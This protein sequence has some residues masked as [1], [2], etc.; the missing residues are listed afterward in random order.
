MVA[1]D[2]VLLC[3]GDRDDMVNFRV[4]QGIL[5]RTPASST[6]LRLNECDHS[7]KLVKKKQRKSSGAAAEEKK[8]D[9]DDDS[10]LNT[11]E[12]VDAAILQAV[13]EFVEP[14]SAASASTARPKSAAKAGRKKA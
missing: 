14:S 6:V 9:E 2:R 10:G 1:G 8:A 11:Q 3:N 12:E 13:R 7:L 5:D 4:L